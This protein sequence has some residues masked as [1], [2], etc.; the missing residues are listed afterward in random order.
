MGRG[1]LSNLGELAA[2]LGARR[3]LLVTDPGIVAAG[4]AARALASLERANIRTALFAAI[5][6]NPTTAHVEAGLRLARQYPI[7]FIIGLGGGSAMDCAKAINL[8]YTNGGRMHDYKGANMA[9]KPMLPLI[10]VPTTAGSGSEAQS[11]ALI[12]DPVTHEKMACSDT[13]ALPQIAILDA[14]LLDSCPKPVAAATAIDALSHAIETAATTKRNDTSRQLSRRA[15]DLIIDSLPATLT[16]QHVANRRSKLERLQLGAHLAGA[17]IQNSM[18]GA[19][20]ATANPLTARYNIVHGLAVGLMLPHVIRFNTEH[21]NP[22]SDLA[23]DPAALLHKLND[24][25]KLAHV[26]LALREHNIPQSDLPALAE[27]AALQWIGACN[28]RPLN[29]SN[30]LHI[31][32]NAW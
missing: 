17:A 5:H 26:P 9:A 32:E 4:H 19:A 1:A 6:E 12:S 8:L 23:P 2:K 30:I 31:Y 18:L 14:D 29:T 10:A 11:F 20:H 28:P 7:D 24:L 21:D 16:T 27:L 15:Y 13:K 25:L 3:A 22:Y